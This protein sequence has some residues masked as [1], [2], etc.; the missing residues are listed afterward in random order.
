M[1]RLRFAA[2]CLAVTLAAPCQILAQGQPSG[3]DSG[4]GF[5]S[6]N[7]V[8][9]ANVGALKLAFSFRTGSS[10]AHTSAPLAA[11]GMLLVLTPFPHTLFALDLARPGA[12]VRW[13]YTPAADGIANGLTCCAA[14]TG[15]VA[16][17]GDRVFLNTL[18]G[19]AV[20]L[21]LQSGRKEWDVAVA[22]PEAGEVLTTAPLPVKTEI[23]IG[24]S[25]DDSGAR[26]WVA[27]LDAATG[28]QRWKFFSTGPDK[29]VGIDARFHGRYEG[30]DPVDRGVSTWP[31][32]AW[33]QGGGGLSGQPVYDAALNLLLYQT[34]HPAPWNPDQR[35]GENR[36][37]S[38]IFAR[39]P[40]T[41]SA[42]WFDPINPHD[43]YALGATGGIILADQTAAGT[44]RGLLLHPDGN[45]YLYVLDRPTGEMLRADPLDPIN[46]TRGVDLATGRL[47]R[48]SRYAISPGSV[49]RDICPA[50]P[51]GSNAQPAF[52]PT[53]GLIYIPESLLC[54]DMEATATSYMSGT[55]FAGADVRLKT[56]R[57][58]S[59]GALVGWDLKSGH[60]A[61]IVPEEF[62]LRGGVLATAGGLVFY[63][64]L[65]GTFK[66]VDAKTGRLLWQFHTTSGIVGRPA[67]YMG[68][69][70]RQYVAVLSGSGGLTGTASDK[71][72][73]ARDATAARGL[74]SA[75]RKLPPPQDRS[76]TLYVFKLP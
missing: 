74:A 56:E 43:L 35:A 21:N 10:G 33:Q 51:A 12:S 30:A 28:R 53:T 24:S 22:Q 19:H 3:S 34:G 45:G 55:L 29:D 38:G 48:D 6:L 11:G 26:G 4:N 40:D 71:E 44:T 67:S 5:S 50:W 46:A 42:R 64:T 18:D 57:G 47:L 20:A 32:S 9:R 61:W 7:E 16:F 2:F 25:G 63:G 14:A 39:D 15:G 58:R 72:V 8:N 23:V 70:G 52:S 1:L 68:P 49:V 73:D 59:G 65:D 36:W 69:E 60:R 62:P 17:A 41:G 13:H 54:M 75:L 37:T 76:G 27:A 31:A 66:A